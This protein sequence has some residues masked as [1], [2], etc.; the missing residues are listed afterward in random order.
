MSPR[1][2]SVRSGDHLVG[3]YE[4]DDFLT[5][6]IVGFVSP[7]LED[8]QTALV[9]ATRTHREQL[10]AALRA[11]GHDVAAACASGQLTLLDAHA[12]RA[13]LLPDDELD[14]ERFRSIVVPAVDRALARGRPVRI[15]G[16]MVSLLWGEGLVSAALALEDRW[17]DLLTSRSFA[18][19][20]GY[21]MASFAAEASD[22]G[23]LDV[24]QRHTAVGNESYG[25]LVDDPTAERAP[26]FLR[27]PVEV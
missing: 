27:R 22:G 2:N 21:P 23:F 9:I 5:D 10:T 19:L 18:L 4:S 20:C 26:V 7:A 16:E 6:L 15:F 12:T 13:T 17:N 25:E 24:C 8:D 1:E 11:R 14:P 3:F